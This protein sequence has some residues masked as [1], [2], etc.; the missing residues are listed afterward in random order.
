MPTG[1]GAYEDALPL[2]GNVPPITIARLLT[3]GV[4]CAPASAV[5]HANAAANSAAASTPNLLLMLLSFWGQP[6]RG[7]LCRLKCRA[8]GARNASRSAE[9]RRRRS[10]RRTGSAGGLR[11]RPPRG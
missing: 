1:I 10:E 2:S 6:D 9:A 3:P 5:T 7:V 8:A 11:R 4:A